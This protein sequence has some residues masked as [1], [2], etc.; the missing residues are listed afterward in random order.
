VEKALADRTFNEQLITEGVNKSEVKWVVL[1]RLLISK[2]NRLAE[3]WNSLGLM[4]DEEPI[5]VDPIVYDELNQLFGDFEKFRSK[6]GFAKYM[7]L[8]YM[9][10]DVSEFEGEEEEVEAKPGEGDGGAPQA[11]EEYPE[12]ATIFGGDYV[13][14]AAAED[15]GVEASSEEEAPMPEVQ[16]LDEPSPGPEEPGEDAAEVPQV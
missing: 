11:E 8:W 3:K 14:D 13:P 7:E 15:D 4:K 2:Y 1:M 9:G 6:P 16:E 12:G 5:T 10:E